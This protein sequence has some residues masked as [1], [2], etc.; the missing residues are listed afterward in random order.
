MSVSL[1]RREL[2]RIA[3]GRPCGVTIGVF[4]GVH[5]GHQHLIGVL[6]ERARPEGLA[7]VALTFN[8]HPRTVLRPG[9]AITYL[10]S[11]EERV[12]LLQGQGVDSV[13]VVAFTSELAQLSAEDFLSLLVQ[14]LEMRL[15]VV[16]PDFA[17]GRNRAGTIG[18]MREIGERLGFRVEVAP[19]LAEADE[20]VGSSAIRQA[21]GAGD[22]ERVG[23]LLGRPFSLRGPIVAGDR[24]GRALGFPTANIALGLDRALPAYG[25]FVTRAYVRESSHESCTSIGIRPTFDVEPRPVVETFILDFDE[26]IYGREMQI[27]LLRRLRGEERFASAEALI[28]QIHKD[29]ENTRE[30]FKANG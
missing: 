3:P 5:R 20:K 16:G 17:L 13:G 8:P 24:R 29:I 6:L 26:D 7:T 10:T 19:L 9:T 30:W 27:D 21:L 12:E 23:R 1:A 2:S 25:I 15:L 14:E 18:V 28:A 11:L 4:D 22:V